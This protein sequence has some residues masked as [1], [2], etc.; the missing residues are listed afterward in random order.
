M[1]ESQQTVSFNFTSSYKESRWMNLPKPYHSIL[2]RV[3][4]IV[5]AWIST[6][7]IIQL[8]IDLQRYTWM[9]TNPIIQ[10]YIE[11]TDS[12]CMN[13]NNPYHS[14][15]HQVTKIV[16]AWISTNPIIKLYIELSMHESSTNLIIQ[17][18]FSSFLII[19]ILVFYH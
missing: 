18:F 9:S 3:T 13:L 6:N 10:L 14:T 11:L 12:G 17:T 1:H 19:Q 7:P 2:H 4:K 5:D 16:D 15:L 8:Y